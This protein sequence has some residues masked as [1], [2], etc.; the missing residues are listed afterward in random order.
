[1]PSSAPRA[2]HALSAPASTAAQNQQPKNLQ[3]GCCTNG[4]CDNGVASGTVFI[5][6]TLKKFVNV[7][8]KE[9][10]S[11]FYKLMRRYV[12]SG[13]TV[14]TLGHCNKNPDENGKPVV[15][16]TQDIS[17]DVDAL[18]VIDVIEGADS[19][20]V[21]I[22]K[23]KNRGMGVEVA[24]YTFGNVHGLESEDATG[25]HINRYRALLNTVMPLANSTANVSKGMMDRQHSIQKYQHVIDAIRVEIFAGVGQ[26]EQIVEAVNTAHGFGKNLI[27]KV[28]SVHTWTS[29]D[30]Y[31]AG[32]GFLWFCVQGSNNSKNYTLTQG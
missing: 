14:L 10:Q 30:N 16:G 25:K 22:E 2:L 3:K 26:Q 19:T 15:A 7:M 23:R 27:R 20:V 11:E 17:D 5:F 24:Y 1:V 31:V 12:M 6:D 8:N 29:T 13:G 28:L 21:E 18:Y 32:A 4:L 9:K